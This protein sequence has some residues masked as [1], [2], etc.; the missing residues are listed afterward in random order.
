MTSTL[1]KPA[2]SAG[3]DATTVWR[4]AFPVDAARMLA[5]LGR[6]RFDP[7]HLRELDGTLWRATRLQSGPVTFRLRQPSSHEVHVD[8]W[9]PA[10]PEFVGHL[11][12]L[13]GATDVPDGFEPRHPMVADAARRFPGVRIPRTRR[14]LEALVP[15]I[16]E[17]KVTS[18]EARDEWS[19]LIR[20]FGEPAPGPTPRPMLV[21]P[22]AATW[23][24]IP[25][26]EWHRTGVDPKRA[27]TIMT[28]LRV[29]GRLEEC[30]HLSF[31]AAQARLTAVPGIGRW[32]A[33]EVAQRALG[34]PDSVSVGD[35]HLATFVGWSLIGK[36]VDDDGMLELLEPWRGHRYRVVRL[37]ELSPAASLPP[38]RGPRMSIENHR[39]R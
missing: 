9:G 26:W 19:R 29:I 16:L 31:E 4:P 33:A 36:P 22:D 1:A 3:P 32:T 10:A 25:S 13:L 24:R 35:Y 8:A 18:K 20:R 12:E 38:R 23:L 37:L 27:A 15:A 39:N 21:P 14:V 2:R 7:C 30:V 5:S 11:P 17:Q 6:G 34:D 28:A